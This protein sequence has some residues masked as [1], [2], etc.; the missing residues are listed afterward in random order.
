MASATLGITPEVIISD[1]RQSVSNFLR[2]C[3]RGRQ[4]MDQINQRI[5]WSVLC[6]AQFY[7]LYAIHQSQVGLWSF[8]RSFTVQYNFVS[9]QI[10]HASRGERLHRKFDPLEKVTALW[11]QKRINNLP[12]RRS[13]SF[14]KISQPWV[15]LTK[16]L[17]K[18]FKS[19]GMQ[20]SGHWAHSTS[21]AS[22]RPVELAGQFT[23]GFTWAGI[24][25]L[26][27]VHSHSFWNR[28]DFC[29]SVGNLQP[30]F[31]W[32]LFR[33]IYCFHPIQ[34]LIKSQCPKIQHWFLEKNCPIVLGEKLVK[35]LR[36]G[37]F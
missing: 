13:H 23:I 29:M 36:F 25:Q 17:F 10:G 18:R 26:K 1:R 3:P 24:C 31:D 32:Y 30:D 6:F 34:M 16:D 7:G 22:F 15:E 20:Q 27:L 37:T 4:I 11:G 35:M 14:D 21:F 5:G 2:K 28:C 8:G 9:Y 33:W 19:T 12:Q